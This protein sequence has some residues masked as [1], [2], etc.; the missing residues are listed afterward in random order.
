MCDISIVVTEKAE[1]ESQILVK[2]MCISFCFNNKQQKTYF[3]Q[4]ININLF[5]TTQRVRLWVGLG[6]FHIS[7]HINPQAK[8][9][10]LI[11][12]ILCSEQRA[13]TQMAKPNQTFMLKLLLRHSMFTFHWPKS[14]IWQSPKLIRKGYII[15][16]QERRK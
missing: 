2:E 1:L 6:L 8:G 13:E 10:A 11:L 12:D 9:T 3:Q 16:L 14:A 15:F 4:L 7:S 5:L